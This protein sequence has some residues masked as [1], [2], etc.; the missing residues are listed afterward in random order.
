MTN[1]DPRVLDDQRRHWRTTF[2]SNPT[3][4]GPAPSGPALAA[5]ELFEREGVRDVL[6]LG[7]G[8]GR[9]TLA[10]LRAGITMTALDYAPEGLT[11]LWG[12]S[13]NGTGLRV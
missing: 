10:F 12:L 8:Q 3:M 5:L 2:E 6:E 13:S 1:T 11:E 7:A 9:D 4:Y